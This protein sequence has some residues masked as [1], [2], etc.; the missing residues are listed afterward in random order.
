MTTR[1]V[2]PSEAIYGFAGWLT[3]RSDAV[4]MGSTHDAAVVADLVHQYCQHQGFE[5]PREHVY[6]DNLE[7][8]KAA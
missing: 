8:M 6:P 1:D 5:E 7:P 3:T 4:T 2:S